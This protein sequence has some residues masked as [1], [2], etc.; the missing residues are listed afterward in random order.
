MLPLSRNVPIV[1]LANPNNVPTT[2]ILVLHGTVWAGMLMKAIN[3]EVIHIPPVRGANPIENCIIHYFLLH[4]DGKV[5]TVPQISSSK[6][7]NY[8]D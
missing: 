4:Y 5:L 1:L 2:A 8:V 6:G 3:L 7:G